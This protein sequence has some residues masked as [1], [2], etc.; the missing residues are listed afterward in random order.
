[1]VDATPVFVYCTLLRVIP[2]LVVSQS[3]N[4]PALLII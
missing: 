3:F 2:C 1:M 4:S